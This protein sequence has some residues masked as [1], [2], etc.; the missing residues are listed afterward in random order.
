MESLSRD[1]VTIQRVTYFSLMVYLCAHKILFFGIVIFL[2]F[3][4]V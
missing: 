4:I 1:P 2:L 3:L